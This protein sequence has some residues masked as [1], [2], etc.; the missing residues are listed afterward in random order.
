MNL[1]FRRSTRGGHQDAVI[2]FE[3]I[4]LDVISRGPIHNIFHSRGSCVD[5]IYDPAGTF[6]CGDI[7]VLSTL[8]SQLESC[9]GG[10]KA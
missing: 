2:L 3:V 8:Q 4:L 7:F 9:F 10:I 1:A 5:N 6:L